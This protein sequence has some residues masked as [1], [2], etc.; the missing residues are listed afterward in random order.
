MRRRGRLLQIH[1]LI[2]KEQVAQRLLEAS[3]DKLLAIDLMLDI[4]LNIAA[5]VLA[6]RSHAHFAA[7]RQRQSC[8]SNRVV[9]SS[10]RASSKEDRRHIRRRCEQNLHMLRSPARFPQLQSVFGPERRSC[11]NELCRCR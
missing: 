2:D 10:L 6:E 5:R 1:A 7:E 4:R 9:Q 8:I 3:V 11:L